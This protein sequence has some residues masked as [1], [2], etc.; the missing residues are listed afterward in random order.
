MKRGLLLVRW[1][2]FQKGGAVHDGSPPAIYPL[3]SILELKMLPPSDF[4]ILEYAV[5]DAMLAIDAIQE[6]S[7]QDGPHSRTLAVLAANL[8]RSMS[9]LSDYLIEKRAISGNFPTPSH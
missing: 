2:S 4:N 6:L 8:G 1:N 3:F 9:Y 7:A 5:D